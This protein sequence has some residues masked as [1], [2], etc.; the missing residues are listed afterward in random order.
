MVGQAAVEKDVIHLTE[1]PKDFIT[2]SSGLG[3]ANPSSI[4][5]VKIGRASC[6][7]RV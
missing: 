6:R 5:I 4:L 7:E 2:I 3:E 1:T